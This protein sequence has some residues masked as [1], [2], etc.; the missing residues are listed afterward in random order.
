MVVVVEVLLLLLCFF[1]IFFFVISEEFFLL[2][3]VSRWRRIFALWC[4]KGNRR[5]CRYRDTLFFY[6]SSNNHTSRFLHLPLGEHTH[7]M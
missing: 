1:P 4:I 3:S 5:F 6:S 7:R 2:C